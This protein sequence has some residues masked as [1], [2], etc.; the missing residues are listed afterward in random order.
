MA[1]A[2]ST[3]VNSHVK[4]RVRSCKAR[5]NTRTIT[6]DGRMDVDGANVGVGT[7]GRGAQERAAGF[8]SITEPGIDTPSQKKSRM[9]F[10]PTPRKRPVLS[11]IHI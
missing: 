11:L 8:F 1:N 6:V 5:N 4:H 3:I 9:P 2:F 10:M 7:A